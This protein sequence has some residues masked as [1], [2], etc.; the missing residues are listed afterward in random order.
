[1]HDALL[2][3]KALLVIATCD[4]EYIACELV[5]KR[6]A[7]DFSA[8]ASVHEDTEF[9]LIVD[10]DKLLGT[11]GRKGDVEFHLDGGA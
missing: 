7:R 8:H 1:M 11:I 3:G 6:V 4:A 5:T 10:F 2:H 9:A